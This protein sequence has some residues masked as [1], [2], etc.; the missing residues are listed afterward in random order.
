MNRSRHLSAIDVV[1]LLGAMYDVTQPTEKWLAGLLRAAA[2]NLSMMDAGIGGILYTIPRHDQL[3][4][5]MLEVYGTPPGWREFWL[6]E[7]QKP[8]M[9]PAII[10][11]YRT[12]L[13]ST[14]NTHLNAADSP[15]ETRREYENFGIRGQVCINGFDVSQKGCVLYLFSRRQLTPT[16]GQERVF[17]QLAAHLATAYRLQRRLQVA[18][19]SLQH[20]SAVLTSEGRTEH[21]TEA[22]KS[23][24][25]REALISVVAQRE[26]V[27][28]ATCDEPAKT[29][30]TLRGL[31]SK[32]WTL[33]DQ[34]QREGERYV[35]ARE[36]APRATGPAA[37]SARERQVACLAALGRHNKLIAYELGLAPSTVRVL[38]A[39][40][41]AKLEVS[42]R[43]S[44]VN[45]V[46]VALSQ[47]ELVVT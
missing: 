34:F 47:D 43:A 7:H 35:V 16:R 28:S 40:A 45:R 25:D 26:H 2:A 44:L 32:R 30:Q 36:N 5:D 38:L 8:S 27:R 6:V 46:R 21:I 42:D 4:I 15:A 1:E 10:N 31:A 17:C 18:G 22:A 19:D 9:L 39:R 13:C 24:R 41:A 12:G 23:K 11:H 20:A 3:S 37:L 29:L 33:V 14:I